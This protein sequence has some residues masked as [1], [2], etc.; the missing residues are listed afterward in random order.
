MPELHELVPD[1]D[2]LTRL[3]PEELGGLLLRV[4]ATRSPPSIH[5]TNYESELFRN[6]AYPRERHPAI[7]E[8]IHEAFAWLEGQ[9]LIVWPDA[10]NGQHGWRVA[11]R[12]GKRLATEAEWD[13][14]RKANLLPKQLLHSKIADA[15]LFSFA[16]GKYDTA[17]FE[18]FK[19]VEV[20]VRDA[21]ALAAGDLGVALMRKA[22]DPKTGPLRDSQ[23]EAGE[24]QALSD[25]FAGAI[26]SYKNPHSHRKVV[27]DAADAVEMIM[28]ASH[29]LRIVDARRPS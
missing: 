3:E 20:S 10:A 17:V 1:V 8:A 26:G 21:A 9:A 28:L 27:I 12:R 6:G 11:G 19:E 29:L 16:R 5:R 25:L 22:F 2:A 15:V 23:Q 13:A 18:A 4:L 14:Y 7:M 24:R